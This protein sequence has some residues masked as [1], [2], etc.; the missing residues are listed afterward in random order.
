M[1]NFV[2]KII[3]YISMFIGHIPFAIPALNVP[4]VFIGRLAFP[5]FAFLI[6]EGYIHTK[7]FSK[8]LKRLLLLAIISQLP[9]YLLFYNDFSTLYL[10]IY[11]TLAL[12]LL[13]IRIFDKIQFKPVAYIFIFII[14]VLAELSG[15]DFGAIGVLMILAFYITKSNKTHMVISELILIFILFLNKLNNIPFSVSNVRYVLFQLLFTVISLFFIL[16]YNGKLGKSNRNTKIAFYLFYPVHLT[17]LCLIKYM[18]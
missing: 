17:L 16:L 8:Y 11:C 14:A 15:C 18:L 5:I 13:S 4:C 9:A 2:L 6:S 12:G 10:N 7:S 3:A 1:S